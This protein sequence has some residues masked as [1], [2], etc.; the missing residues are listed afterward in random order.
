MRRGNG[1]GVRGVRRGDC[2]RYP[3]GGQNRWPRLAAPAEELLL[4]GDEEMANAIA[5][6]RRALALKRPDLYR[7]DPETG[8]V[9]YIGPTGNGD[10]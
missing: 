9:V 3:G 6:L 10:A 1:D 4:L 2:I 5:R 8:E 7:I